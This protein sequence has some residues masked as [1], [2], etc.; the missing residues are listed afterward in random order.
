MKQVIK[1][2]YEALGDLTKEIYQALEGRVYCHFK[3]G[4]SYKGFFYSIR[5]LVGED[6]FY[7]IYVRKHKKKF[8]VQNYFDDDMAIFEASKDQ[9]IDALT[10]GY[11]GL[12]LG[13]VGNL[14][15]QEVELAKFLVQFERNF[16]LSIVKYAQE[17]NHPNVRSLPTWVVNEAKR[18]G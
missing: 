12:I 2:E 9:V 11:A 18:A 8:I 4:E 15:G 3:S 14:S 5:Y 10:A 1:L 16:L 13:V 6:S 17:N 7:C